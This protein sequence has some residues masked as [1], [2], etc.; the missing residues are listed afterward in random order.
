MTPVR[1][2]DPNPGWLSDHELDEVR[3]R[4]PMLYVEAVPVR[5]EPSGRVME[6]GL[7][8]RASSTGA[9][10]TQTSCN[11]RPRLSPTASL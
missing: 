7:L 1:T 4:V 8:L 5:V 6:V 9:I 2:P 10:P 11:R 3:A